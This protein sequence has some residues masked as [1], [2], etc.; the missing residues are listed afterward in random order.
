MTTY[1]KIRLKDNPE[2]FVKG[3]PLYLSYDKS[4]RIFQKLGGLRSFITGVM[5]AGH[6]RISVSDWE[7]VE[8]EMVVKE[9]KDVH[10][11][12]SAKKLTELLSK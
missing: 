8:L 2:Q 7:V 5:N 12:I 11:I 6:S 10:E 3:T 4:G 1:Y 9:V